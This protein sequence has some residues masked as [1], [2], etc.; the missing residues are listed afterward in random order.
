MQL[1]ESENV[2]CQAGAEPSP[3]TPIRNWVD[4]VRCRSAAPDGFL[5]VELAV[6]V[7]TSPLTLPDHTTFEFASSVSLPAGSAAGSRASQV[8]GVAAHWLMT[9]AASFR[10]ASATMP[11]RSRASVYLTDRTPAVEY[12]SSAMVTT[13]NTTRIPSA[14]T[15]AIPSS[16][17]R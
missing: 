2:N 3:S 6:T 17:R 11:A 14:I 8:V 16:F 9:D 7:H 1:G 4:A 15:S 5:T 10:P 13:L 12:V